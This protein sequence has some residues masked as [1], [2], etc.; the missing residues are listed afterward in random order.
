MNFFNFSCNILFIKYYNIMSFFNFKE[1]KNGGVFISK[2]PLELKQYIDP[3]RELYL[4]ESDSKEL[5]NTLNHI[6]YSKSSNELKLLFEKF[7]THSYFKN[8][9]D[10][11]N[12]CKIENIT[13][14]DEI[15]YSNSKFINNTHNHKNYYGAT[16]NYKQHHDCEI[17]S[18]IFKHT[19]IY[20]I[21][22]GLTD[23][24][25]YI[26]TRFPVYN[27]EK[28]INK[29]DVVGFDFDKTT[30]EVINIDNKQKKPRILLKLHFLV[31][32]NCNISDTHFQFIKQFYV[33]YDRFLRDF[34][35][36]G[37]DPKYPHEFVIG[38]ICH[39][40]YYQY[41]DKILLLY[42]IISFIIIKHVNKYNYSLINIFTIV[43]KSLAYFIFLF[44]IISLF[45]WLRFVI[46]N[47]K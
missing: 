21:L 10:N 38:L 34:T 22:I 8:L 25:E 11:S 40:L 29:G 45:Y 47:I 28:K 35:K 7:Q 36:L 19:H 30:H 6:W 31:C 16:G 23:G 4:K 43:T 9:C 32:E 13:D 14:M 41:M 44:L 27:I 17:C 33:L 15:M 39:F 2:L 20:R 42:F 37:T 18:T 3:I 24:N 12:N 26:V 5:N 1:E 46:F